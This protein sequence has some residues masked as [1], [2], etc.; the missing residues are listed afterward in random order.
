MKLRLLIFLLFIIVTTTTAIHELKH[1][2]HDHDSSTCQVCIVDN[3][4]VSADIIDDFTQ[5]EII[6]FNKIS[7]TLLVKLTHIKDHSCQTRAPP[8]NS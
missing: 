4:S 5:V 8:S 6:K 2:G 7:P 1:I 3:H